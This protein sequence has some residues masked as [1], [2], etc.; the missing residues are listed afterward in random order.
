[1][2]ALFEHW[3]A[4]VAVII[5]ILTLCGTIGWAAGSYI[6]RTNEKVLSELALA[7]EELRQQTKAMCEIYQRDMRNV[8]TKE[9]CRIECEDCNG[10]RD[11]LRTIVE[12]K[13]D[14]LHADIHLQDLKRHEYNNKN[15]IYFLEICER[16]ATVENALGVKTVFPMNRGRRAG[17]VV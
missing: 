4:V 13:I 12:K 3:E 17:D 8:V 2:Q 10:R 14:E 15:Q 9:D 1:M 5:P 7:I 11:I 6:L 16:L